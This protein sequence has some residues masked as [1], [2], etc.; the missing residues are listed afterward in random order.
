MAPPR[1]TSGVHAACRLITVHQ[2]LHLFRPL[3]PFECSEQ[4]VERRADRPVDRLS[5]IFFLAPTHVA[6]RVPFADILEEDSAVTRI[7]KR[8]VQLGHIDLIELE[9]RAGIDT[10]H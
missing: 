2:G 1:L 5:V 6:D 3:V 9:G 8:A 10:E 7:S 4:I